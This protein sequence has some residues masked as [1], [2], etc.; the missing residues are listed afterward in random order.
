[1]GKLD[2]KIAIV[3]GAGRGIGRGIAEKLAAEGARVV[4]TDVDE[5]NISLGIAYLRKGQ[6][7]AARQA[8][9]T[10]K[11]ESKWHNLAELW[12]IRTLQA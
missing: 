1:M 8:F 2:G 9:K 5:A 3:T 11:A 4:V 7:D 10:V 6:K 12:E